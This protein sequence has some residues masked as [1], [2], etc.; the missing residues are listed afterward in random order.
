MEDCLFCKIINNEIPAF[1]V[2]EDQDNI[3]FL[4]IH[5][6]KKGHTLVIPK[7]HQP[8]YFSLEDNQLTNL[9]LFSKKIANILLKAFSPKS[10]KIGVLVY[11]FD[12]NHAHVHLVPLDKAGEL[13]FSKAHP[14][15]NL[16][17]R[18]TLEEINKVK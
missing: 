1:K 8:N 16:E 18:Q 6:I 2:L 17:L 11:G 5:P 13:N 14:A 15:S 10:G 12:M 4:D 3:A 9:T 7:I